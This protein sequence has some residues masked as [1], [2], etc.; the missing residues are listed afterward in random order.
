MKVVSY[1]LGV[2]MVI[3]GVICLFNPESTVLAT[4]YIM[5]ILLLLFGIIGI[6]NVIRK[7]LL[8]I[9]LLASIPAAI[10]GII[11]VIRPGTTLIFD[12]FMIYLFA[13]WYV[14]QGI[15][16]IIMAVQS[17]RFVRGWGFALAMGIISV[18]LGIYAFIYPEI[19]LF[20]IGIMIGIFLIETGIDVIVITATISTGTG[21]GPTIP[22]PILTNLPICRMLAPLV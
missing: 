22:W 9:S 10:I 16:S 7:R 17:R 19:S 4:G 5:A 2:I 20:A 11:A 8:P 6:V 15:S 3:G 1:I 12:A 18:I 21:I 13:G 14:V